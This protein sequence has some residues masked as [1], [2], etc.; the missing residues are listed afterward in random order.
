MAKARL[1][2]NLSPSPPL[3]YV[4]AV[5]LGDGWTSKDKEGR[6]RLHLEV[7][8]KAFAESFANALRKI[9]LNPTIWFNE[10]RRGGMWFVQGYSKVFYEWLQQLNVKNIYSFLVDRHC[11]KEFLRGFYEA[12]GSYRFRLDRDNRLEVR[13]SNKQPELLIVCKTC[14]E[15]FNFEASLQHSKGC[16]M[17][18]LLGGDSQTYRFFE[19]IEPVVKNIHKAAKRMGVEK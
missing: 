19:V 4:L 3:S 11:E 2:P 5:L 10:K 7:K 18:N 15:H 13:A 1:E 8:D 17:L 9:G 6:C 16:Y 12:E 14:L